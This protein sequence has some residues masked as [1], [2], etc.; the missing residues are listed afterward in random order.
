MTLMLYCV[1]CEK[2]DW[3]HLFICDDCYDCNDYS[4]IDL[5]LNDILLSV[6]GE[7]YLTDLK[8]LKYRFLSCEGEECYAISYSLT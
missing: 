7:T 4:M 1:Y 6:I 2:C 5:N 8:K 3:L